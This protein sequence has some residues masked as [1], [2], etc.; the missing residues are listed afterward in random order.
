MTAS[1]GCEWAQHEVFNISVSDYFRKNK[2]FQTYAKTW[3]TGVDFAAHNFEPELPPY[4]LG[5]WLGDGSSTNPTLTTADA[6]TEFAWTAFAHSIGMEVRREIQPENKSVNLHIIVRNGRGSGGVVGGNRVAKALRR[7]GVMNNKHIPLR[8][9][10]GSRRE[11]LELLAGIIDTDGSL[12]RKGYDYISVKKQLSLDVAFLAR[13]L[14][15]AAYV[16]ECKKSCQ[17]GAVGTY[18]RVSIS[19]DL[20]ELPVKL[21]RKKSMPRSQVK[22]VMMTGMKIESIGKGD[23]FGFQLAGADG[24]FLLGDFTVTHNTTVFAA[25]AESSEK[26]GKRVL[27]LCHRIELVD[28]IVERL[29]E[30]NVT[31]DIIAASYQRSGGRDRVGNRAVA[32]ASVQTLIRRMDTY[33]PPTLTVADEAHHF[34][35]GNTFSQIVRKYHTAKLLGVTATAVRTDGRGLGSHFDKLIVGPNV[36]ELT[37]LGFL[38][39][40]RIFAP[41]TVDTSGLHI[42][43]GDFKPEENEALMDAPAITGSALAHYRQHANGLPA[44]IFCTSVAH[45]HH[46]ADQF[47]K[48]HIDAIA[49][50]GGTDKELRRMAVKDFRDGKIKVLASCDL[51]SEGF[52]VPG[53]H[54][55]IFL[56]PTASF[57]L[58]LQQFG[59]IL[60]PAPGKSHAICLDH[61]GNTQRH[62]LPSDPHEWTL[63]GDTEKRKKKPAPGIRVCPK[64]FAASPARASVCVECGTAFEVKPRQNVE[65]REGELVELTAEQIAKKRER[66]EQG[67]AHDRAALMEIARIKGRNPAWVDHVLAGREAKRRKA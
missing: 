12:S 45:A 18:F 44:L 29:K 48:D 9:L 58:H 27:I 25:I 55:G 21:P 59:R 42:R 20:S 30:F 13:S 34:S 57:G 36:A 47:R 63:A 61:T 14:G 67:R 15:V 37:A 62:G 52:D 51:F 6:E 11:R 17:T 16:K 4:I 49:L 33:A 65:E 22:S 39:P 41:P 40:A 56:R 32:V 60:R 7:L 35:E 28:Q 26:R 43:M 64:C 2:T 19:G 50:D 38:A 53:V 5:L 31:P 54:C 46:V 23:Y 10:T 1:N 8:Y 24:L 3:R 66:R